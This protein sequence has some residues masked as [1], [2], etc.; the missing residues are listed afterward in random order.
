MGHLITPYSLQSQGSSQKRGQKKKYEE[1]E[2]KEDWWE[3]VSYRD[4]GSDA[5]MNSTAT[6]VA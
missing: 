1:P 6:V 3:T 5:H 2:V 4:N